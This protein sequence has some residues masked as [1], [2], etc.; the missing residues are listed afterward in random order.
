MIKVGNNIETNFSLSCALRA[1][2]FGFIFRFFPIRFFF[3]LLYAF[4]RNSHEWS[5]NER[6]NTQTAERAHRNTNKMTTKGE[7]KKK[8]SERNRAKKNHISCC[9]RRK[10]RFLKAQL[11]QRTNTQ[12]WDRWDENKKPEKNETAKSFNNNIN[13]AGCCCCCYGWVW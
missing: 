5:C 8:K 7:K 1:A 4:M 12:T 11:Q 3:R 9:W 10:N 6:F 2:I 13:K